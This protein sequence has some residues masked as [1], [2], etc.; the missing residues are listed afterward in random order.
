MMLDY[1]PKK[2]EL[3]TLL[4]EKVIQNNLFVPMAM[5]ANSNRVMQVPW[6]RSNQADAVF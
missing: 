3:R 5:G 4:Y 6:R 2:P 1:F